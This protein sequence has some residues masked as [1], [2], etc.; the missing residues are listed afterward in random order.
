MLKDGR[1]Q[2]SERLE[3]LF[4]D[5]WKLKF[6]VERRRE[7]VREL[8]SVLHT[9]PRMCGHVYEVGAD[10]VYTSPGHGTVY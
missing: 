10:M 1:K 8:V 4:R 2:T 9:A 7:E 6:E 3:E 5:C